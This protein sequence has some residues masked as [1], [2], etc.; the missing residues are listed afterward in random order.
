M[1]VMKTYTFDEESFK[2]NRREPQDK[3][4][5]STMK[6]TATY[7]SLLLLGLGIGLGGSYLSQIPQLWA[8]T[9]EVAAPSPSGA[10]PEKPTVAMPSLAEIGRA[11]V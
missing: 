8:R 2:L 7:L 1:T 5:R 11:H 3:P 9:S 10:G 4:R 6:T